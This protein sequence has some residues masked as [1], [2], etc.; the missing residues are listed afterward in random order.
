MYKMI[1]YSHDKEA[2]QDWRLWLEK[3]FEI[4]RISKEES[5]QP[6]LKSWRP[7]VLIYYAKKVDTDILAILQSHA[8][9][10]S[11]GYVVVAPQY[12]LREELLSFQFA[13]DHFLLSHSHAE[14]V[15]ARCISLAQK[16]ETQLSLVQFTELAALPETKK[17]IEYENLALYPQISI[18]RLDNE[19]ARVTPTQFRLLSAFLSHQDEVLSRDWLQTHVFNKRKMSLR[20]I[21][22]QIAK[23][24]ARIP[25][26]RTNLINFYGKGYLLK[27]MRAKKAS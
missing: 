6:L 13:A 2:I 4:T 27:K 10:T 1:L 25:L 21:D 22:A 18:V 23:L 5:L 24:K 17:V 19:V 8:H 20:S 14:S 26:L 9:I 3:D 15:R 7:H 11:F 16:V 12:D